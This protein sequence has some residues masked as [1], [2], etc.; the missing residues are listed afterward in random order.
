MG[1]LEG[2]RPPP[3]NFVQKFALRTRS[4]RLHQVVSGRFRHTSAG[5]SRP[6]NAPVPRS[7]TQ[8]ISQHRSFSIS[9]SPLFVPSP[10]VPFLSCLSL[11]LLPLVCTA[12]LVSVTVR[13]V[14][15][16]R[17]SATR[18]SGHHARCVSLSWCLPARHGA[19]AFDGASCGKSPHRVEPLP[20]GPGCAGCAQVKTTLA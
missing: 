15:R 20:Q 13:P 10:A 8:I 6:R 16:S 2:K 5:G 14:C 18:D 4:M 12:G 11:L 1:G 19:L 9:D 3:D 17:T 7:V